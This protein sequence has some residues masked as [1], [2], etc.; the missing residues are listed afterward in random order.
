MITHVRHVTSSSGHKSLF[1]DGIGI[2]QLKRDGTW[3]RTGG[4][5]KGKLV[6]GVG[7]LHTTLE[8]GV[9]SITTTDLHTLAASSRLNRSPAY[10]NG[11]VLFAER[12]NLVSAHVPSH[13]QRSLVSYRRFGT[14]YRFHL[15]GSISPRMPGTH[16]C[17]DITG[18]V[19]A[20]I[21]FQGT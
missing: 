1:C 6:N 15:R 7:T 19:W 17:A 8:L 14:T 10:L 21:G 3:R 5:V 13:F 12:R 2:V 16:R 9:S 4:E 18:M 11:L 20:K